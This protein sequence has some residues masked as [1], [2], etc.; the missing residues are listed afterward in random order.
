MNQIL[1]ANKILLA[2][3]GYL[4]TEIVTIIL[5]T[6]LE[7]I[8][9][10]DVSFI[11]AIPFFDDLPSNFIT[12]CLLAPLV[13]EVL[14]RGSPM[15]LF[16]T[17]GLI[18]GTVVWAAG[19]LPSRMENFLNYPVKKKVAAT[20]ILLAI[21]VVM[22]VYF[23]WIWYMGLGLLAIFLHMLHNGVITVGEHIMANRTQTD[24]FE[25]S[26]AAKEAEPVLWEDANPTDL[27][28]LEP[29]EPPRFFRVVAE[30]DGVKVEPVGRPSATPATSTKK[31]KKKHKT[32]KP[33]P[34]PTPSPAPTPAPAVASIVEQ[35]MRLREI[36]K[37]VEEMF[38]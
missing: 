28:P 5:W 12:T 15:L 37:Y 18:L 33:T 3:I 10:E 29:P 11:S 14:F 31:T 13:E 1:L 16:G 6:A 2:L 4:V 26:E 36:E 20:S 25:E 7:Y 17:T 22:G 38:S 30:D 32:S 19:H 24:M 21:Y 8:V 27:P 35:R 9:K 34:S 23:T